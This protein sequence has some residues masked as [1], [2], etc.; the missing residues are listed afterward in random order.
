MRMRVA[1]LSGEQASRSGSEVIE[2]PSQAPVVSWSVRGMEVCQEIQPLRGAVPLEG[3]GGEEGGRSHSLS[4]SGNLPGWQL[5]TATPPFLHPPS[6]SCSLKN[7]IGLAREP[8]KG[9]QLASGAEIA[10]AEIL[11]LLDRGQC[12]GAW[13]WG[14]ES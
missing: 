12:G 10:A 4:G 9:E 1:C 11:P 14:E 6:P 3:A 7:L 5:S 13:G 2:A 8:P